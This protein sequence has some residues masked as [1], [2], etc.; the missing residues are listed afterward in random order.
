MGRL[1]WRFGPVPSQLTDLWEDLC[2]CIEIA[3]VD[4]IEANEEKRR[5]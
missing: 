1:E 2:K 5:M 3:E 4:T